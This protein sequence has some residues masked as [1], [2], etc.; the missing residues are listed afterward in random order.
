MYQVFRLFG[1]ELRHERTATA[2]AG[3]CSTG[4]RHGFHGVST[5]AGAA[6]NGG[7]VDTMAVTDQ[8]GLEPSLMKMTFTINRFFD[9]CERRSAPGTGQEIP[10]ARISLT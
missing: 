2:A 3:T 10:N 1:D 4:E 5:A 8:H 9:N 6:S 7:F